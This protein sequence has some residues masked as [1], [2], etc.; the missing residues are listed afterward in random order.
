M[1]LITCKIHYNYQHA[2]LH[3]SVKSEPELIF[4]FHHIAGL[5]Q[6]GINCIDEGS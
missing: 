6:D 2:P 5:M 1:Y 4:I 3:F